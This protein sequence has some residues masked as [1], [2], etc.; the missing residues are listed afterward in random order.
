[1]STVPD[2]AAVRAPG[3]RFN[4]LEE[5]RRTPNG[6]ITFTGP[7]GVGDY[8]VTVLDPKYVGHTVASPEATADL[9]YIG[10]APEARNHNVA[11]VV[12]NYL[13][14]NII[15]SHATPAPRSAYAGEI[16]WGVPRHADHSLL[17]TG[18]QIL[19]RGREK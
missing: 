12:Y 7:D 17:T 16:G 14:F 1:M 10:R 4:S 19:V 9:K 2:G 15:Q 13:S 18:N 11:S 6:G 5:G 8:R 3:V